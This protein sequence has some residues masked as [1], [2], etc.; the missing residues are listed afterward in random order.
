ME[1]GTSGS[2]PST[3]ISRIGGVLFE[4]FGKFP[5]IRQEEGFK[6]TKAALGDSGGSGVLSGLSGLL[7]IGFLAPNAFSRDAVE[8]LGRSSTRRVC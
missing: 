5:A 4:L 2:E 3:D 7:P 8:F 1:T 6:S